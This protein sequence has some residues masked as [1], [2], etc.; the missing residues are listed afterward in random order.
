MLFEIFKF[1]ILYR[2]KRP[3]T[4]VFFAALFLYSLISVEFIF[5]DLPGM[6]KANAPDLIARTMGITTAFFMMVVSIVMGTSVL[7]DFDY[8]MESLMFI[9]PITKIQYLTGRFLGSFVVLLGIFG[10]L[11]LGIIVGDFMP[12]RDSDNML[13]F[14]LWMY[15]QPFLFVIVPTLFFGGALF[16]VTGALTRKLMLVYTQGIL[17]L[18][19][20]IFT[21]Q[22]TQSAS[23]EFI[24]TL[25]D[26]FSFKTIAKL[27]EFWSPLERNTLLVPIEGVLLYNRLFWIG[28]GVLALIV[29]Y[30]RFDFSVVRDKKNRKTKVKTTEQS[31]FVNSDGL[32]PTIHFDTM[33]LVHQLKDHS[34]FFFKSVLKETSFWAIAACAVITIFIN[35]INLDTNYGVDS[36]PVTYLIISELIEL[37]MLFF[38]LIIVFYSGE[39]VWKERDSKFHQIF[40]A[41]PISDF[42][43][44]T[45]KFLGLV[46]V[47]GLLLVF[48]MLAGI[49]FQTI[50]GYYN[51]DIKLY[52]MEFFVGIFPFLILLT[53]IAFFFQSI[54]NNKFVA[55]IGTVAFLFAGIG[56]VNQFG[57]SHPLYTFGGSFL[58]PFSE[59]NGYGHLLEPYLWIKSYWF[60]F[61]ILLFVMSVLLLTRGTESNIKKRLSLMNQKLTKPLVRVGFGALI[62]LIFS[63]S[64]IFY[65]TNILNVFS[66]K[67]SQEIQRVDY[68]KAL[69]QF[70]HLPQPKIVDAYLEVDL[71]PEQRDFDVKGEFILVNKHRHPIKEIHIQKTPSSSITLDSLYFEG[72]SFPI[73][74]FEDLGYYIHTL[75]EPLYPKDSL[76]MTF[77][78]AFRTQGFEMGANTTIVSNGTFLNHFYFPSIGYNEQVELEDND[79]REDNGLEPKLR[80]A[81]IDDP[82]ALRE[83]L[84]GDDGEEIDFE[85]IVSTSSPQRAIAPGYLQKQWTEKDRSFYHYKMDKLMANF[86]S[87]VSA[88]YE[89]LADVLDDSTSLEIYYQKGHEYNLDRMM[90]GMK[91]SL[92]YFNENFNPYQYQQLRIME[93]PRYEDFAQSYPNTIPFSEALGFIMNIDDEQDVDMAF[94]ITAHETA[95]QWWGLHVNP[96][97]VQGKA[98]LSE[99]LA[100]YSAL[101]VL[102]KEFPEEKIYQFLNDQ[103]K[104][105]LRDRA[106][107]DQQEMPLSLVESGQQ[108][109]YYN[110]GVVN[111]YAFQDYISEDSVNKALHRFI[112]DWN[113]V[114]GALKLQTDRYPTTQDLMDYFREVT[115]DSLQYVIEDLFESVSFYD[116]KI[117]SA[118]YEQT[119]ENKFKVRLIVEAAKFRVDERGVEN[120]VVVNDWIDI[121]IYGTDEHGNEELIY[122]KKHLFTD[123]LIELE[124]AVDQKPAKAGIDP[125]NKLIDRKS[126]GIFVEVI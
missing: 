106:S 8:G 58:P 75:N 93:F 4:Y 108:Y 37:S 53:F 74:D 87:I 98:M 25:F 10:A 112:R 118:S 125:F 12:W 71:F 7:R 89:V 32:I 44:L 21:L 102:K 114:T 49:L 82:L 84:S 11:L 51:F 73:R 86:Y 41:L 92:R 96:A 22:L 91:K 29:G 28:L 99:S 23:S 101:M 109:V 80:R 70:E 97:N 16:F 35:S 83:G 78:Q 68:E 38:L 40:D 69:K 19:L 124:I 88:D 46:L 13:P 43:N 45:G 94:Y 81:T 52:F 26:P 122:L 63:G 67:S 115:P 76:K 77:R 3:E 104:E 117:V 15:L 36:Y 56:L 24:A 105:Y 33:T 107:E 17:F 55:H 79:T 59:M 119:L 103:R 30:I 121:G 85:I 126:E 6:I 27:T 65:N 54:L 61:S 9:N 20:Y 111:L 66:F 31:I 123:S 48:M 14:D 62:F 95:H 2:L 34:L 5:G 42:I 64:Y 120:P 72:G 60:S 1:E 39:L 113:S 18:L 90:N 116:N 100:Q 110:K 50:N 47:L 57:W